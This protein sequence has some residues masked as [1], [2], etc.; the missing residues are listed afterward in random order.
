MTD[1][2]TSQ[3]WLQ[4]A[5]QAALETTMKALEANGINPILVDSAA[6]AK[7]KVLELLPDGIDVFTATSATLDATGIADAIN[8]SG[9]YE[10]LRPKML[11]LDRITQRREMRRLTATPSYVVGSVHAITEQGHV[12]IASFGGS[13][14]SPYANGAEKVIWVAGTH[15]L[16]K[17]TDAAFRRIEEHSL[18][19]E[20][21]R[22]QKALGRTSEI[23]K[24]LIVR[25][26]PVP[27]RITIVLGREP[28]G[29]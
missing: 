25:K 22:L 18:P 28:L 6:E 4:L 19:L 11:A 14:L 27:G 13:Q 29:F 17:D 16:V 20:S 10:A 26:E 1:V 2:A 24:I 8:Q 15:K 7:D 3:N 5:E 9:H 21:E 12:F 23:G